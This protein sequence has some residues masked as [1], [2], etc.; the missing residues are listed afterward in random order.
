MGS[1]EWGVRSEEWATRWCTHFVRT[2]MT[3]LSLVWNGEWATTV[4][5]ELL[6]H[7]SKLTSPNSGAMVCSSPAVYCHAGAGVPGE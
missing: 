2:T 5:L 7:Y 4:L 1:E 6:S 3:S